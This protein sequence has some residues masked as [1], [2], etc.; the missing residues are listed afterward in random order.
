MAYKKLSKKELAENRKQALTDITDKLEKGIKD[1][2]DS[3]RFKNYLSV[4]G[5]FHNYSVSNTIL[6]A[7]Q[8]PDSSLVAGYQAW[9]DKFGRQVKKGE[10]GIKI[11]APAPFKRKQLVDV[12]DSSGHPMIGADG[13][14][15][16]EEVEVTIPA[17]KVTTVFDVSST[18]GK[19]LP[20]IGVDE[21][22]GNV[23]KFKDICE[24]LTHVSPVPIEMTDISSGAKGYFSPVEQKICIQDDMSEMQT[25]KTMIH[26]ISHALLHDKDHERVEGLENT[27]DKTR[28]SKEVEAE[29]VA[30][31]VCK[32][33][34]GDAI[35]TSEY[36]FGYIAGWSSDKDLKE[37]K[38][39]LE[40]IR[41][42][43]DKIITGV[44]DYLHERE[45]EKQ[46]AME[47]ANELADE[48][49]EAEKQEADLDAKEVKAEAKKDAV[50][51]ASMA[52]VAVGATAETIKAVEDS[53]LVKDVEGLAPV[54]GMAIAGAALADNAVPF[55][56]QLKQA[57]DEMAK[58]QESKDTKVKTKAKNRGRDDV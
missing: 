1:L 14:T 32:A 22:S 13:K 19:E 29:A 7:M 27:A 38:E 44:E 56:E 54:A 45:H 35:D 40:T 58:S 47:L 18:E 4:M 12:I 51:A 8:K 57:K 5:K 36:S 28:N 15:M 49:L 39:S 34:G 43:A 9:K 41:V 16:K 37:L 42:T 11:I 25:L 31:T 46:V 55:K 26:E 30:Y 21:L 3:D 52:A 24:A 2:M 48:H 20:T 10:K 33:L 6:I 53:A 50:M 17:F 23:D